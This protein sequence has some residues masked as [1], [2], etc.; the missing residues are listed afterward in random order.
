M[1]NTPALVPLLKFGFLTFE[2]LRIDLEE[3]KKMCILKIFQISNS[4]ISLERPFQ[5]LLNA[6]FSF[7]INSIYELSKVAPKT[8]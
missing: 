2:Y 5:E 8:A 7:K 3:F 1:I 6:C 4:N